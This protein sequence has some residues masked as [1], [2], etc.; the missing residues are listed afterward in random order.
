M[1]SAIDNGDDISSFDV[2]ERIK[3]ESKVT[4]RL[5]NFYITLL[6]GFTNARGD[7]FYTRIQK[8]DLISFFVSKEMLNVE[9]NPAQL[10]YLGHIL[11]IYGKNLYYYH[12]INDKVRS[13]KNKFSIPIKGSDE[14]IVA[15]FYAGILYLEGMIAAYFQDI[16]PK[17]TRLNITNMQI[18]DDF[19]QKF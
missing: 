18:L 6:G 1:L 12:Y 2:P 4:E 13:G 16:N 10:E 3:R 9:S 14:K 11:Y 5:L 8:P 15:D 19:K 17:D 7:S